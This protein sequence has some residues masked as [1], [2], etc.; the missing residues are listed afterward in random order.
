[1]APGPASIRLILP[2]ICSLLALLLVS[3]AGREPAANRD[4]DDYQ[5][6]LDRGWAY[7]NK[8]Q[9]ALALDQFNAA[10]RLRP[11][12]AGAV[13]GRA[14]A[15]FHMARYDEALTACSELAGET[16][17]H[18]RALGF[19][20]G[21]RLEIS[22]A[23]A[24][25]RDEVRREIEEF[26]VS[27]PPSP[28][29]LHS[30][31]QGYYYLKD[32][33]KRQALILQLAASESR[34]PLAGSI[35][36]A[37]FDEIIETAPGSE[38]RAQLAAG[39]I[40]YFP[41]ERMADQAAAIVL[42]NLLTKASPEPDHRLI[43]R[44][45][46]A[47]ES[48]H[49]LNGAAARWL[50]EHNT[51]HELAIRLLRKNLQILDALRPELPQSYGQEIRAREIEKKRG[52]YK[53]L[54]GRAR[55]AQG[56]AEQ[57]SALFE[58]AAAAQP[59]WSEPYHYLGMIALE[60]DRPQQALLYLGTAQTKSYPRPE[61]GE[62]L[63]L[64]LAGH[65]GFNGEPLAYFQAQNPGVRFTD[66]TT[67]SGLGGV[68]ATRV[69]WGDCDNDGDDDLLLNGTR[70]FINRGNGTFVPA[71][72]QSIPAGI[73]GANGGVWGDYDNDGFPDIFVTSHRG[74]Q[75]LHNEG[76]MRFTA[77]ATWPVTGGGP[78]RPEAAAWGDLNNDGFLD[79][80]VANYEHGAVMRAQCG[81][82]QLLVNRAG[83]GLQEA[84]L[85]TGI[86]SE[87]GMCG[88]GVI[89]SDLNGDGRQDI[90]VANYRLD[91]N[92]LWLNRGN[93]SLVDIAETAGVR[94]HETDGAFGHSIGAASGDLDGDGDLDI[95]ISN[96]AHPRYLEF[97]DRSMVLINNGEHLPE[98]TE[99]FAESGL[100]FEE[101][102][103][104]PLLFDADNDGD[105]D[106]FVTSVYRNRAAH[107]YLNDGKGRF[108]DRT[109]LAGAGVTNGWGAASADYDGDGYPDLL[110][111]GSEGVR[112]LRNEGGGNNWLAIRVADRH[113]NRAGVGSRVTVNYGDKRQ[114]RE[115][116]AG[117]GTGSQDSMT[118]HFGLGDHQGPVSIEIENLCGD[119]LQD[120]TT[121]LNRIMVI[122]P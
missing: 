55:L 31:Y 46:L 96:L 54:L 120:R 30:A 44:E 83:T 105:L 57:A 39:Y 17:E 95:F 45:I 75:L 114:V 18:F 20:W 35:A 119:M 41:E 118:A 14:S 21:A 9:H 106:L 22:R 116:T 37:L 88:R 61:T 36:A 8:R 62:E 43:V 63:R 113:C 29:L 42:A 107:L 66:A 112:L 94:G 12:Q 51:G 115:I 60:Q 70:L 68:K 81:Q 4:I 27:S 19:C 80:Y 77:A 103:A 90:L 26:L 3:C 89:W 11:D 28:E 108:S 109:W 23:A 97:S 56:D 79:L 53:Y 72:E 32:R 6:R 47:D 52:V 5:T 101:T 93:G 40:R 74:N 100:T 33:E 76:G 121:E 2:S 38:S 48:S 13:Y 34:S 15:L 25:T 71:P 111:A 104:D 10:G 122:G 87:E 64:L 84:S 85:V 24:A 117:R 58:E 82:D 1:M 92:F 49:L 73:V 91:P 59:D 65:F 67:A 98:F 7:L 50:V 86:V 69:A 16:P 78:P 102:N 110:V 99:S